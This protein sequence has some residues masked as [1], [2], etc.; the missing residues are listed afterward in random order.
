[1]YGVLSQPVVH[2]VNPNIISFQGKVVNAD[3]TNVT[4]GTYSFDFVMY[5]DPTLGTPNDGV[6]DKWR[7]LGKSVTVTNGIFQTNLGSATA[8][9][10]FNANP[11]LY[12]AV[13]FNVD[14]AGYMTPRVQMASVPY[15]LNADRV[16][17][18]AASALGQLAS[19]QTWTGINT[20]QPTSNSV[21][22]LLVRDQNSKNVLAV[23]TTAGSVILGDTS[24]S[25]VT[26]K[27]VFNTSNNLNSVTLQGGATA[28]S[29]TLTM[30][31]SAPAL[32]QC[33]Q[34]DG[35]TIG[36]LTF[37]TCGDNISV[38]GSTATDANFLDSVATTSVAGTSFVLNSVV[39][40][41]TISLTISTA[42]GSLA[43]IVTA[44]TQTIGGD[45]T[46]TGSSLFGNL[47]SVGIINLNTTGTGVT[48]IGSTAAGTITLTT[49]GITT[50][51][52]QNNII[53]GTGYSNSDTTLS[54]LTLDSS[55]TYVETANTC[56]TSV[57]SG[58]IYYNSTSNS[59]RG[60]INGV[61]EDIVS[62]ASLGLQLFGIIPDSGPDPGNWI[63]IN[64][65]LANN[66]P[67]K[68]YMGSVTTAIRWTGC[69]AYSGGRKIIVT[70][71]T[72]DQ[73]VTTGA[74]VWAHVCFN[75]INNQPTITQSV[76]ETTGW[77][78]FSASSPVLCLASVLTTNAGG[79]RI[80]GIY[81]VRTFT[82]SLKEV[83]NN[84]TNNPS[85]GWIA[86]QTTTA[87]QVTRSATVAAIGTV[88]GVYVAVTNAGVTANSMNAIIAT[89]GPAYVKAT[90]GTAQQ[91][92]VN[93]ITAGYATP[94]A[95]NQT[96]NYNLL[97]IALSA[98]S[99]TCGA[100]LDNC[101]GSIA[102][103]INLR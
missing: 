3:G 66:G 47:T 87:G 68:V 13:R 75:G 96:V 5:D 10:D 43:G 37:S 1:M 62:T 25:G 82:T 44:G 19:N 71:Q 100:S 50:V 90:A 89:T 22:A 7:E 98:F 29:F 76:T 42:N 102:V 26:G 20:F 69:T 54:A 8:L 73:A 11:S 60:C 14:A 64:T 46:F 55:S 86:V 52:N 84:V 12:L 74:G 53:I 38:N 63:G 35:T 48:T 85:N 99:N 67:C 17:G 92:V 27:L 28:S 91:L 18:V 80:T 56:T 65:T 34:N 51:N 2:A 78:T 61:W 57:N 77:P 41:D 32:S 45:K 79:G 36:Q 101:R 95:T 40:P 94:T 72:S 15:A 58:S 31:V 103:N 16:G 23:S 6:R 9:P 70:A 83:V 33:L 59:V 4:N 81:D 93:G 88:R 39:N 24:A 97:G 30:P 49:S 21:G